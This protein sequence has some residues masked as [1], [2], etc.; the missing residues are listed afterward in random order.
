MIAKPASHALNRGG[1]AVFGVALFVGLKPWGFGGAHRE[2]LLS[3]P[4]PSWQGFGAL[5]AYPAAVFV[6]G[7]L[8][9]RVL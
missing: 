2:R 1:G 7:G 9:F 8:F 6:A 3:A 4:W 5:T